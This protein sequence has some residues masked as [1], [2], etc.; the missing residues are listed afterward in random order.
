MSD[1]TKTNQT[2]TTTDPTAKAKKQTTLAVLAQSEIDYQTAKTQGDKNAVVIV[3][4]GVLNAQEKTLQARL[5]ENQRV[6]RDWT[7][8]FTP[9]A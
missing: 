3:V 8:R 6:K 4:L 1:Q 5:T 7:K 9:E 2:E